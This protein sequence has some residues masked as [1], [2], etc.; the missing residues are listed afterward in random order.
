MDT[1][2]GAGVVVAWCFCFEGK[3]GVLLLKFRDSSTLALALADPPFLD[4][5]SLYDPRLRKK[6]AS[7]L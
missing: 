2:N 6:S 7:L 1:G 3:I 4:A 5:Q